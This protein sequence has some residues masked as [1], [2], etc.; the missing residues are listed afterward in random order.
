MADDKPAKTYLHRGDG[1]STIAS[2][3]LRGDLRIRYNYGP[4]AN[5]GLSLD[6]VETERLRVFLN[7]QKAKRDQAFK[8]AALI[9][10]G[11][12]GGA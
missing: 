6:A 10:S 7:D 2:V 1:G 5:G 9:G 12:S 11:P 3:D 8:E 4:H